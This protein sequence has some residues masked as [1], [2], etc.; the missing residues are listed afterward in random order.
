M[1]A[2]ATTVADKI[3]L[4]DRI[5]DQERTI[6]YLEASLQNQDEQVEYATIYFQLTEK[7]SEFVSLAFVTFGQLITNLVSSTSNVLKM[8]FSILPW[9]IAA[10][11]I[12]L[13]VRWGRRR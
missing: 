3:E 5:F 9:I 1:L 4:N 10:V 2:E 7:Q 13:G 8:L 11:I 6:K 12:W